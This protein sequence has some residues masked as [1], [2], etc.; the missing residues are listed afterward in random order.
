MRIS[1]LGW[2]SLIWEPRELK[3]DE[4]IGWCKEGPILPLEFARISNDGRLTLVITEDGTLVN[5]LYSISTSE[6]SDGTIESL[7]KREGTSN[8]RIGW[9]DR[10]NDAFF[11]EDFKYKKNIRN[12]INETDIDFVVWTNLY[13]NWTTKSG[14]LIESAL[15]IKY[16]EG[17]TGESK[18]R[19]KEYIQKAPEQI[20]TKYRAL[21]T[22]HLGW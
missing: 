20:K 1:I 22:E 14:E 17:L 15:R 21:I 9:Y 3:F 10:V 7:R 18:D 5:T 2:G 13:D 8:K 4:E 12:W 11:E 6:S 16:L 19:A